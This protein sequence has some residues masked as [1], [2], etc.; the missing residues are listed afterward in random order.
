MIEDDSFNYLFNV[1]EAFFN[2]L[3][4]P[5]PNPSLFSKKVREDIQIYCDISEFLSS[6]P[7]ILFEPRRPSK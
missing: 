1:E 6:L 3:F 7:E 2:Y 4:E 5:R